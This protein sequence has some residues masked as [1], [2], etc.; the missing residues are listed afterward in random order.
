MD[1]FVAF[2]DFHG[3]ILPLWLISSNQHDVTELEGG[4][5]CAQSVVCASAGAP[6]DPGKDIWGVGGNRWF[7]SSGAASQKKLLKYC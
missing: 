1:L 5:K 7:L 3:V 4:K 2:L 6:P